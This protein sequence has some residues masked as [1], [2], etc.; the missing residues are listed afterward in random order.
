M[1]GGGYEGP[2]N[3]LLS[4]VMVGGGGRKNINAGS[5]WIQAGDRKRDSRRTKSPIR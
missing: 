2:S 5:K 4:C 3:K 1:G